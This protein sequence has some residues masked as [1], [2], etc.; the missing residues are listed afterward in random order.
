MSK[1]N[2]I[3]PALSAQ[4][5]Q[6]FWSRI[7]KSPGLGPQGDCWEWQLSTNKGYGMFS[8]RERPLAAHRV[9]HFLSTGVWSLLFICHR[10]DNPP[11]CNPAHLFEGTNNDNRQDSKQKGRVPSG[12]NHWHHRHPEKT[13][14]GSQVPV[15][16]LTESS[17]IAIRQLLAQG[18]AP[19]VICVQYKVS[20]PTMCDIRYRRTWKHLP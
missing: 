7:D 10:C 9:A 19:S 1:V 12:V 2:P 4:D 16:K 6:Q 13:R 11:C 15:S 5:I 8:K 20:R 3:P 18:V 14:R 17:V